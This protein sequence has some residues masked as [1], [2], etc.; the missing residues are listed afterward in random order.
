M[1]VN[2]SASIKAANDVFR[3][4]GGSWTTAREAA[5]VNDQ[6]ELVIPKDPDRAAPKSAKGPGGNSDLR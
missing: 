3:A 4:Y 1:K 6:G 5:R 2:S